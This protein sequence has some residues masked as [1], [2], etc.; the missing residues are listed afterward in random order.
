MTHYQ[1]NQRQ[2]FLMRSHSIALLSFLLSVTY[3]SKCPVLRVLAAVPGLLSPHF[4]YK[5]GDQD[6]H[7]VSSARIVS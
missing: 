3:V 4:A 7:R 1:Y 5:H 6:V 2:G